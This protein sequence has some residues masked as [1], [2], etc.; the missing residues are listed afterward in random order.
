MEASGHPEKALA[1]AQRMPTLAPAAGHLVHMP[2]HTYIRTGDYHG[3]SLANEKAVAA[4]QAYMQNYHVDDIYTMM[5]YPHNLQFLAVS[6]SMEGRLA[7]SKKAAN[8]LVTHVAPHLKMMQNMIEGWLPTPVE[9]LVRFRQW[10][11]LLK[12]PTPD[13]TH[14]AE[15]AMWNFGRGMAFAATGKRAEAE[16]ERQSMDAAVGLVPKDYMIGL[17]P[18]STVLA[19]A[20]KMLDARIAEAKG[21]RKGAVGLLHE[22]VK[23]EDALAYDEPPS[24]YIPARESRVACCSR[25]AM[26]RARREC[27]AQS[28]R[29]I[30]IAAARCSD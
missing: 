29:C 13:K 26:P 28:S 9:I 19:I 11:D 8:D 17:N 4:D 3:A 15:T 23:L 30:R 10:N 1:S 25:A 20:R 24:W 12:G 2:A 5:Y 14:H 7:T 6:A 27:S 21:D 16:A 22:T 18:A